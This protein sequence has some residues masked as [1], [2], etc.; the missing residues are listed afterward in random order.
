MVVVAVPIEAWK[1]KEVPR[2]TGR[3]L[4][5]STYGIVSHH[6]QGGGSNLS[7]ELGKEGRSTLCAVDERFYCTTILM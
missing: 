5:R 7:R 2:R 1:E 3:R 4:L 6:Y